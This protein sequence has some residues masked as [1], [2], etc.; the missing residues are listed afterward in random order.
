VRASAKA[1]VPIAALT[2]GAVA[3]TVGGA[4]AQGS[5][6]GPKAGV[7]A[8]HCTTHTKRSGGSV[9]L[10]PGPRGRRGPRG[11]RGKKGPPGP[12]GLQGPSAT[13][14]IVIQRATVPLTSTF[15]VDGGNT[16]NLATVGPIHIDGLCRKT[17]SPGTGGGGAAGERFSQPPHYPAPF[18][19][20][21]NGGETEA[22]VMV[23]SESGSLSFKGQVGERI[24]VPPGP[25][26]YMVGDDT[27]GVQQSVD[28][29]AGEGDHMFVAASNENVDETRAT[30]PQVDDYTHLGGARQLNRYPGFNSG[31]GPIATST[32]HLL[33]ANF[34]AGFDVFGVHNQCVFAGV[35]HVIS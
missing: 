32:G 23:W 18:L 19:P 27:L 17:F 12:R 7:A 29:V 8:S 25:P 20:A 4:L 3:A 16:K 28:P 22:K 30:D 33:F 2:A 24:N 5:G 9:R 31:S 21:T 13:S 10:C 35:I 26:A 6:G 34:I 1:L 14:R 15:K 11:P